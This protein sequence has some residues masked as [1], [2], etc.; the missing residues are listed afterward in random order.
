MF[1]EGD[2]QLLI[3]KEEGIAKMMDGS[4][5]KVIGI[6]TINVASRDGTVC[7][8]ETVRH[9]MEAR[10]NLISIGVLDSEGC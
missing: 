3:A 8:L 1:P 9:V 7:A 10:H 2:V 6:G 4:A 5:C